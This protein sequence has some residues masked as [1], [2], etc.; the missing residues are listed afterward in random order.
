MYCVR[1]SLACAN[2]YTRV[3]RITRPHNDEQYNRAQSLRD[4]NHLFRISQRYVCH[5]YRNSVINLHYLQSDYYD[6]AWSLTNCNSAFPFVNFLNREFT[7]RSH[8][9]SH[10]TLLQSN[11]TIIYK[12]FVSENVFRL[13]IIAVLEKRISLLFEKKA[14]LLKNCVYIVITLKIKIEDIRKEEL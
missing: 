9:F 7:N 14:I 3:A 13:I 5:R 6:C 2:L 11:Q 8:F 1:Q 10:R 12:N 4:Y